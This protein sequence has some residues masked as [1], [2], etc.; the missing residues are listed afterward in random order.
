MPV[1]FKKTK[2][3]KERLEELKKYKLEGTVILSPDKSL[4]DSSFGVVSGLFPA[5]LYEGMSESKI[6]GKIEIATLSL[7]I[8]E[9][10]KKELDQV[11]KEYG[12][13]SEVVSYIN[14]RLVNVSFATC[15]HNS[16]TIPKRVIIT[17]K[18]PK[19]Y[20][21]PQEYVHNETYKQ[22]IE[23]LECFVKLEDRLSLI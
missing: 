8:V 11:S 7:P 20:T 9:K 4:L 1:E 15:G 12:I 17:S 19:H 14:S 10:L 6:K 5:G 3:E 21:R 16:L 18:K 13:P 23:G 22:S 2:E